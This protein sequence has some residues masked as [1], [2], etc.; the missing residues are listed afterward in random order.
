MCRMFMARNVGTAIGFSSLVV[1]VPWRYLD[2]STRL[3]RGL[4]EEAIKTGRD[5][6][7]TSLSLRIKQVRDCDLRRQHLTARIASLEE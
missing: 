2:A 7:W 5:P 4:D 3:Q 6:L 1:G